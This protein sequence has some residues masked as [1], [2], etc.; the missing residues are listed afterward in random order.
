MAPNHRFHPRVEVLEGRCLPATFTVTTLADGPIGGVP[1]LSLREAVDKANNNLTT[2][3]IVFKDTLKGTID[4]DPGQSELDITKSL[5][6]NGPGAN[7]ITIDAQGNDRIFNVNDGLAGLINVTIKK[8]SLTGGA[9]STGGAAAI[10]S[11]EN[12]TVAKSRLFD[13]RVFSFSAGG[14]IRGSEGNLT[15][16]NSTFNSNS[17][18]VGG[19]AVVFSGATL[20]VTSCSFFDN[21]A[22][23]GGALWV[24][25]P[26]ATAVIS[27][28]SFFHNN[29]DDGGGAI[30]NQGAMTIQS[31]T[32]SGNRALFGTGTGGAIRND[33]GSLTIL[34][35][36][37]SGNTA[38]DG[39]AIGI[40][41]GT[42]QVIRST[43]AY[44]SSQ[45]GGGIFMAGGTLLV[46]NSTL[47]TNH[48]GTNGGGIA[49]VSGALTAL[50]VHN[51]T[52]A[53]NVAVTSGGGIFA[54]G[55]DPT[56]VSTIVA[57]NLAGAGKDLFSVA[58]PGD[59]YLLTNCFIGVDDG[60]FSINVAS[61]N[62]LNG[63]PLLG[64]LASNGGPT[65][66]HALLSG[67]L[68]INAGS[69]PDALTTDQRGPSFKRLKGLE[70]DIGG[71]ER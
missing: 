65:Q 59:N 46:Q 8:L 9:T 47:S 38:V 17:A 18:D 13:N 64:P 16:L 61:A 30:R 42:V 66:T 49:I 39:G 5:T 25:D 31:S 6:I 19:G 54:D 41:A 35:S 20:T 23:I 10:D 53:F 27:K 29:G 7:R 71:F 58:N 62:N 70:V 68:A 52:I 60:D 2:D 32:L 1:G 34:A 3:V 37:L 63:N 11:Q 36:T 57:R 69:N 45:R 50:T 24:G 44:N 26:A 55:A 15:L 56:L 33:S 22:G 14:A 28:S 12:L 67:S 4:L 43:I 21:S 40:N 51:S 48:A